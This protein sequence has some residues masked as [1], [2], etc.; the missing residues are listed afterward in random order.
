MFGLYVHIPFCAR[1]CPYCDFAIHIGARADFREAYVAALERELTQALQAPEISGRQLTSLFFGG[2]TPT[3]VPEEA[4]ALLLKRV[5]ENNDVDPQAEV[6]IE[7]NPENLTPAK[8][9]AL[10]QAGFNRLSLGVQSLDDEALRYL[11]RV[12]RAADVERVVLAAREAGWENVSLDLIYAVPQQSRQAWQRTLEQSIRLPLTHVSC[13]SLTIE[14][15]TPF[16]KRAER[17]TLLP[18]C[19]DAQADQMQ[20]A[21]DILQAAGILRYEISNYARPGFESKHNRNYWQG[22]DYL[23]VGCGAHGHLNGLRWWNE[24]DAAKYTELIQA[25]NSARTGEELLTPRQRLDEVVMLGL[26]TREGF[27]LEEVAKRLGIN[28]RSALGEPLQR[29]TAQNWLE[30]KEG[31]IRLSA[32][33]MPVADAVALQLLA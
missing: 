21:H 1:R 18:V 30:E 24:R 7:A 16:G 15:G 28:V 31:C 27:S 9:K 29:L 2:G 20:D 26:R 8:L 11:G 10:R 4:L 3:L 19:D 33:G 23:A 17:G 12:H 22:G 6:T 14:S 32:R 5:Y 25:Q 13:Y